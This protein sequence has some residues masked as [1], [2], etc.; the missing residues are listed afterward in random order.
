MPPEGSAEPPKIQGNL[1]RRSDRLQLTALAYNA[2]PGI[3]LD[4]SDDESLRNSADELLHIVTDG[5]VKVVAAADRHLTLA[6]SLDGPEAL[7]R[8]LEAIQSDVVF[9]ASV[10]CSQV[11]LPTAAQP[12]VPAVAAS[13]QPTA[14][15]DAPAVVAPTLPRLPVVGVLMTPYP[16]LVMRDGSR[17][18]EGAEFRGFLVS[19]ISEEAIVLKQGDTT[20]EWK[21]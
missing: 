8:M 16:C 11:T 12:P 3:E 9:A 7:R 4:L 2:F 13:A 14:A 20:L 18:V 17:V 6:G 21:P 15:P 5:T 1:R 10:D 19:K